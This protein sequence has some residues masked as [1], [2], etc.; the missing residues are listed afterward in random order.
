M[1]W[2]TELFALWHRCNRLHY[3]VIRGNK[4]PIVSNTSRYLCFNLK[5]LQRES[6]HWTTIIDNIQR[7]HLELAELKHFHGMN[8]ES[9]W[10]PNEGN[11][12][13]STHNRSLRGLRQTIKLNDVETAPMNPARVTKKSNLKRKLQFS[14]HWEMP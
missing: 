11:T 3:L 9:R 8:C 13:G 2:L 1:L 10:A 6:S 4:T 12:Y 5:S 14:L 7:P